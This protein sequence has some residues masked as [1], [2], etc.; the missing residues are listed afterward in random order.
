M[1]VQVAT[2][3]LISERHQYVLLLAE[4][5]IEDPKGMEQICLDDFIVGQVDSAC[6][7]HEGLSGI[8]VY[9]LFEVLHDRNLRGK[10]ICHVGL[11]LTD[12]L[13]AALSAGLTLD[14]WH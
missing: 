11:K 6:C 7:W 3:S 1:P 13:L 8:V 12:E 2:I 10:P 9:E 14:Y 4:L 5:H